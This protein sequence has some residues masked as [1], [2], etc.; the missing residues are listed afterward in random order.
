MGVTGAAPC[1]RV[2]PDERPA[3]HFGAGPGGQGA[4]LRRVSGDELRAHLAMLAFS[5][6]VAGSFSLGAMVANDVAPTA[7]MALRFWL[8][9]GL[10]A[11]WA[12]AK[13][14]LR[15]S[16][17]RAPWRYL[18]L[19]G[20][21]A[22]Y[23]AL[24]FEGLKT[25]A[26]VSASA[27]FTLM[28][29]M[30]A[31][32]GR[33][34]LGQRP[35]PRVLAALAVG[36]M[37][38]LWVIFRADLGALLRFEIGRGEVVYFFG[39]MAHALYVPLIR[40]L[41]RGEGALAGTLGVLVAGALVL[42]AVGWGEIRATE[43]LSLPPL[44]WVALAYLVIFATALTFVLVQ[45]ASLRL[46]ASRVTAYTYLTPTWVIGWEAALGHGTPPAAVLGGVAL[47]LVSVLLLLVLRDRA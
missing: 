14:Q 12:A 17:W 45:Y 29:A 4:E 2:A 16:A 28:P 19:G 20:V 39:C 43:W 3:A 27:V 9:A 23:F 13:G 42:T 8:A 46:P 34:I 35:G 37:G 41:N 22:T 32:F 30:A 18:V 44:V 40:R 15:L 31:L 11:V 38:A 6:L 47:T 36:A 5:A 10:I 1:A 26:P 7:L 21:F 25:A 24:M 33:V